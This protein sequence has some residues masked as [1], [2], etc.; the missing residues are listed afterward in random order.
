MSAWARLVATAIALIIP[1]L[2]LGRWTLAGASFVPV[3]PSSLPKRVGPWLAT[4][5]DQL[6]PETLAIIEPD[7][8]LA[9]RY[10]APGRAPIWV[11]VG[12]YGG[13]AGYGKGAHDPEV[14]YPA[15]G[16]EIMGSRSVM[17]SVGDSE[18]M[19][20][21][22]LDAHRG[23]SNEAVLYWFQPAGRWSAGGVAEELLRILDAAAGRPQ[24]AFV[25]LSAPS[26]GSPVAARDLAEFAAGVASTI[27]AV[28]SGLDVADSRRPRSSGSEIP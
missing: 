27:R 8:Y 3:S 23:V 7:A 1:A 10:D 26:D 28:V 15:H 18:T 21:K 6:D 25:R 14:C 19:Q 4:A 5:E 24:Y 22:L 16:W 20:A 12:V 11:Y 9:R 2:V 13:R 17:L